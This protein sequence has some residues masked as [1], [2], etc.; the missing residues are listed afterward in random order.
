MKGTKP[1]DVA[2]EL[3]ISAEEAKSF[4]YEYC[5]LQCPPQFL[6][7]YKELNNTNSF[8]P[9]T[10]LFHLIREKGLGIEEGIEA[11]EMIN[12][13]FLLKEKHRDL[14]NS[15]ANL[16]EI[17]GF[18]T[19][20]NNFLEDQNEEMQ[21]RLNSTTEKINTK[22]K[23]LEIISKKVRETEV[24]LHKIK[25]G[26]DYYKFREE[27]KLIVEEFLIYRI[28]VIRLAVSCLFNIVKENNQKESPIKGLPKSVY[29]YV[30]DSSDSDVYREKLE[31]VAEKVLDSISHIC[32][33]NVLN[34]S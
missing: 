23:T 17:N 13:I 14:S 21:N 12:D 22:E 20:D 28:K 30:S 11:I 26:E 4:Y 5:S 33:D 25:S 3:D 8:N 9:F 16:K 2:I 34:T 31:N 1:L 15:I 32:T 10:N 19:S 29:E 24:E 6:Q 18:L 7:V 27:V